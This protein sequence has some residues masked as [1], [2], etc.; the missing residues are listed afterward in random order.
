LGNYVFAREG[1]ERGRGKGKGITKG[2]SEDIRQKIG[3]KRVK[4][5][6]P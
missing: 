6:G 1:K 3:N 5:L 4:L 2:E